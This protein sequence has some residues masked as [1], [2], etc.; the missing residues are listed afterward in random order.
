M[1]VSAGNDGNDNTSNGNP[2]EANPFFDKLSHNKTAKNNMVVANGRDANIDSNGDLVSVTINTSSSEGPTDDLRIKP[3]IM[4]NGTSVL[5]TFET[6]DDAYNILSGTSMAAPNVAGS[7]LL[8]QQY[9][10][11]VNGVFMR[12]S[13]LKGLAL[14]TTDDVGVSGPD[15]QH[16]WGLMN[17][18][19]AAETITNNG[20][21]SWIEERVLEEGQT[22]SIT[23]KS[24]GTSPLLASISWTDL[25]GEVL[26]GANNATP[27]LVNDLD[28]RVTQESDTF[29]PWRLTGVLTND[30]GDNLVDP[31]ERVEVDGASGEYTITVSHKGTL[32]GGPQAFALIVTGVESNFTFSTSDSSK[33]VCSDVDATFD[34]DYQQIGSTTTNFSAQNLPT[35]VTASFSSPSLSESGSTTLTLGGLSGV[36]AGEYEITVVGDD[37]DET[38]SRVITLRL[39]HPTFDNNPMVISSPVNESNDALAPQTTLEWELNVNAVDYEIEV[40]DNP[41]FSNIVASGNETDGDLTVTGLMQNTVYYWRIR[42]SNQCTA[43]EY[44]ET[45]SFQTGIEECNN[46]YSATDFSNAEITLSP[47]NTAYVPISITDDI[48]ISRLIVQA[49]VTH[50]AV[51]DLRLFIQQPAALGSNNTT[52]LDRVCD[53]TDNIIGVTFDDEGGSVVCNTEAPAVTG[54]IAPVQSLA[55]SSG[56]SS[57]GT[58][59][60]AV[61]DNAL[62]DGGTID[63]A[64]ITVC[65]A[66]P[67]TTV[68]SFTNNTIDVAANGTYTIQTSD[69]E[70]STS[71]EDADA[72]TYTLVELPERGTLRRNGSDLSIGDTFTQEDINTGLVSYRNTQTELFSD[73]FKVNITNGAGGWLPNQVVNVSA[74]IV[75]ADSFELNNFSVFP[76]P[77]QGMISVRFE[78]R[79]NNTVNIQVFDLQGRAIFNQNYDSNESVFEQ[80]INIGNLAN[81]VYLVRVNQGD[82]STVKNLIISK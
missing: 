35:G 39:Y 69:L 3:D 52:L 10:D 41:S 16:G 50:E 44:S 21:Q 54:V 59:F 37:G 38:E 46:T 48:T 63:A 42:P 8:L 57:L 31:Y 75:S 60:F 47:N 72:Q 25:P 15:A 34:F 19:R 64:S 22:Y 30:K 12:A 58:W 5:S 67:N 66:V 82:R 78:S 33:I 74:S 26:G 73:T 68:P 40:S 18:K 14:H 45:Y 17:T 6:A 24:D 71:A 9:Y 20:L 70:A 29:L 13:T 36:P 23:V 55:G 79:T 51:E 62:F 61:T 81:G 77:S 76:N 43:G 27:V 65:G 56:L 32:T 2:L 4:G 1:V 49:D 28:I 7:L 53:D 11:Q 80:R